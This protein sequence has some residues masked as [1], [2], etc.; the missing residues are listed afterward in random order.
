M[1]GNSTFIRLIKVN[2][3]KEFFYRLSTID[4][5]SVEYIYKDASEAD[6]RFVKDGYFKIQVY[7]NWMDSYTTYNMEDY[8]FWIHKGKL[9]TIQ[10]EGWE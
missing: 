3:G 9:T 7:F 2:S 8:T 6:M 5:F 1:N 4:C 10:R